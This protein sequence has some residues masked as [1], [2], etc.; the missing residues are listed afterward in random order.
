M[1]ILLTGGSGYIGSH[2]CLELIEAGFE[3][4]VLDNLSNSSFKSIK[5]VEKLTNSK[6]P[7]YE[8]DIC[9]KDLMY[10]IFKTNFID[11]VIHAAGLKS[12]SESINIP[13]EYYKTNMG[14]AL[15]LVNVM[16]QFN[17][18]TLIFSSS[19]TVYG[20]PDKVPIEENH[21]LTATNPYGRSK[22]MVEELLHDLYLSDRSWKIS[23]LRYFNPVGA[24]K[25]G[26]I[27]EDPKNIPN[28]LFPYISQVASGKL[29]KLSI[30][31]ND[32]KT[33]DGTGIRDYIHIT[34]LAK[35]HVRALENSK[36]M[37]DILKIN[38]GKGNGYSV[39]DIIK[40]YEKISG[41]SIPY[42]FVDRRPGDIAEC[43]SDPS[44]A[45]SKLGWKA[46]LDINDMCE[47]AWRW[48][49]NNPNGYQ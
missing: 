4:I 16:L 25:S 10:K 13:Y 44:L 45:F 35:G 8:T 19:A 30:F 9:D 23:I 5:R 29:E 17:C 41:R 20:K 14:G 11:G 31:G 3:V 32:Y 15:N 42:Q 36:N 37:T 12:V 38:L 18:K 47:D 21:K 26:L 39:L 40:A 7:F 6:I 34:D 49:I 48:Q 27:G 43:F 2:I 24:H 33:P 1:A 46:K 22:I 28:N